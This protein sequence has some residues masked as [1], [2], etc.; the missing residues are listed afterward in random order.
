MGFTWEHIQ[1]LNPRLIFGS[2]KCFSEGSPYADL[3]VY[4]YVA[5]CAGGAP[6]LGEHTD[7]VLKQLGYS[8]EQIAKMRRDKVV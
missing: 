5:Q 4:Y 6:L 3:K 1:E 8:A 7:D 2:I